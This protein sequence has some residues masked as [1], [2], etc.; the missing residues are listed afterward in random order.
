MIFRLLGSAAVLIIFL[1]AIPVAGRA[2]QKKSGKPEVQTYSEKKESPKE[3]ERIAP[4]LKAAELAP[5]RKLVAEEKL[6]AAIETIKTLIEST[7][8]SNDRAEFLTRLAEMYW[9]KSESFFNKAYGDEMFKAVT[10]AQDKGDEAEVKRLAEKQ[11]EYLSLRLKWQE[12]TVNVYKMVVDTYPQYKNVDSVLYYLG[13]TL[14]LMQKPDDG[15]QYFVR[16]LRETPDSP[17]IPDALLNIGE[18]FFNKNMMEDSL[19]IYEQ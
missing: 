11:Q 4:V 1:C 8:D 14:T 9:D 5:K 13:F 12:E 6:T 10:A 17:Y 7:N 2:Q 19:K 15:Y 16:I 3:P 18:Y